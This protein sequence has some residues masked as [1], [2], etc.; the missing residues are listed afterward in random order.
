MG[1]LD[2]DGYVTLDLEGKACTS[3]GTHTISM[4]SGACVSESVVSGEGMP[5]KKCNCCTA[6][7]T[8]KVKV[9][10][11]C[12]GVRKEHEIEVPT[13]C[14]CDTTKCEQKSV[15]EILQ[16]EADRKAAEEAARIE[17]ERIAAEAAAE[18]AADAA[19]KAAN[20]VKN[21]FKGFG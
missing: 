9:L 8:E 7:A 10:F 12:E 3:V 4:C 20:S 16:E 21:F 19:K 5:S 15:A 1:K 17:A 13:Q 14:S 2:Y 18:A 6:T 11:D